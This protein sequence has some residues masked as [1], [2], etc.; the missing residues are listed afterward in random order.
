[1]SI[2]HPMRIASLA[3]VALLSVTALG[4]AWAS[5]R[6]PADTPG[7]SALSDGSAVEPSPMATSMLQSRD[8]STY[9]PDAAEA[10]SIPALAGG[11]WW[12]LVPAR[13]HGACLVVGRT[14]T[15]GTGADIADGVFGIITI[16]ETPTQL[17]ADAAARRAQ[18][19]RAGSPADGPV[20]T[21]LA[22]SKGE[23][24]RSGV[25]PDGI[26]SVVA[27]APDGSAL[28]EAPVVRNAYL[29]PLGPEG[30]ASAIEFRSADGSTAFT[31]RIH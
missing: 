26:A 13:D 30:Q 29:L 8:A 22:D 7:V 25:V 5:D 28:G 19:D 14:L 27:V 1:M 11:G 23:A 2:R 15:C 10:R 24:A 31:Y 20:L 21:P 9:L 16:G 4:I 6:A 12:L 3:V 18:L 17:A